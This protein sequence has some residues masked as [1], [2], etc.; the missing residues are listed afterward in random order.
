MLDFLISDAHAAGDV[1]PGGDLFSMGLMAL[2]LVGMY[3]FM[4]RPQQKRMKEHRGMIDALKKGDE[5]VSTGGL[6][7]T[8]T[9]V[10]DAFV[11]VQIANNIEVNIQKNYVAQLLPKGTMKKL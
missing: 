6:G 5:V 2:V 10:N 3:F 1:P 11:T 8:V 7:G 4:I 9:K